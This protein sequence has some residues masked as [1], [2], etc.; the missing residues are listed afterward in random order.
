MTRGTSGTLEGPFKNWESRMLGVNRLQVHRICNRRLLYKKVIE[1]RSNYKKS[2]FWWFGNPACGESTGSN[3]MKKIQGRVS[4]GLVWGKRGENGKRDLLRA[5]RLQTIG[6][7]VVMLMPYSRVLNGVL[8]E[9]VKSVLKWN[10]NRVM[11]QKFHIR[12][13]SCGVV[14]VTGYLWPSG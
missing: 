14:S 13:S 3:K 1:A 5:E 2:Y 6:L 9:V 12:C 10:V 11:L 4:A 8:V 7:M